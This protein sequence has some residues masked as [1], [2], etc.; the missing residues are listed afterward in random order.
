M[1]SLRAFGAAVTD[2]MHKR[3]VKADPPCPESSLAAEPPPLVASSPLHVADV[4]ITAHGDEAFWAASLEA[5]AKLKGGDK[6]AFHEWKGIAD[7]VTQL[8]QGAELAQ[9]EPRSMALK[10]WT[11]KAKRESSLP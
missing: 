4:L 1:A 5:I 11:P 2:A 6:D 3:S 9:A 8:E 7:A 10:Q